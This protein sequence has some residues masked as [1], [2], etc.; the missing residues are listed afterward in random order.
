M[1]KKTLAAG[2]LLVLLIGCSTSGALGT[3]GDILGSTG[4]T[5]PSDI[6]GTV[7]SVDIQRRIINLDVNTV[8]NLKDNRQGSSIYFDSNTTVEYQNKAYRVEDLERG[9]QIA[10]TGSNRSGQYVANRIVVTRNARG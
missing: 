5:M 4:S 10:V 7:T 2:L 8:N 6:R 9:D 3:L 1:T